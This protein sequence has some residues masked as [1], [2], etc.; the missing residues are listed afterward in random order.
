[1][2]PDSYLNRVIQFAGQGFTEISFQTY[3]TDWDSDA[4]LTVSGQ[5]SN[6]S[7]R[8]TNDFIEAVLDNG[9]WQL[10]RRTDGKVAETVRARDLWDQIANAA[11]TCADPGLQYDTTI[12]DWHTCPE[13]GRINASNPCSEYMFLDDTAC[14][15]ASLNLLK[16]RNEDSSFHVASFYSTSN[17]HSSCL[18]AN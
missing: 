13:S 7:V 11:W 5:N 2:I 3:T 9:D 17:A 6:N 8:V 16:F 14:N 10:I 15:L 4:Y 1:M 12:N 18:N